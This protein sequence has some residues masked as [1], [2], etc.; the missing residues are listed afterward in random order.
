MHADGTAK[1]IVEVIG[2]AFDY[3]YALSACFHQECSR[4][5]RG[6]YAHY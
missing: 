5:L 2:V 4:E 6:L 1:P 3:A